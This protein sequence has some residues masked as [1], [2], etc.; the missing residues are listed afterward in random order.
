MFMRAKVFGTGIYIYIYIC[1]TVNVFV[2]INSFVV[3]VRVCIR[4]LKRNNRYSQFA[5]IA[6]KTLSA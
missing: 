4:Q 2:V 5:F 3:H 1:C 6:S